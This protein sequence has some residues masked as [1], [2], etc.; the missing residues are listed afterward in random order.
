M[1]TIT[2]Y[3]TLHPEITDKLNFF[4][5]TRKIPNIIF[6]G[7]SGS[8]K[9]TIVYKFIEDIYKNDKELIKKYVMNVNCAH[10]KGIKF[11]REELKFFAKTHVNTEE[12]GN[13]KTIVL[14]NADELTI[15]A[16]S[17]LRRCIELFS[18]TTRFFIIVQDKYK[19]LKPILSRLCEI[20][21]DHPTIDNN[22]INLH[23]H[24]I[25]LN[26][27]VKSVNLEKKMF[28]YFDTVLKQF[29]LHTCNTETDN[30]EINKNTLCNYDKI[31]EIANK[32]YEKGYSGLDLMKYIEQNKF[33]NESKKYQL[34][35]VFNKIKKEFRNEKLFMFFILNFMFRS[36]YDLENISFI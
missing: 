16:Q 2:P 9:R 32:L 7:P 1:T 26:F 27:N 11:V 22:K 21:I 10:G 29:P 5:K 3:F 12:S 25:E 23:K 8:G 14:S 36:D 18:H 34:L 13:F 20:F 30:T 15:D 33:I 4:I 19:L 17:A 31:M 24:N 6:H 35:L 28:K